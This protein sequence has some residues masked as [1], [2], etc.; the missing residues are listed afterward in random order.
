MKMLLILITVFTHGCL[1]VPGMTPPKDVIKT[2]SLNGSK[3][4]WFSMSSAYAQVADYVTISDGKNVDTICRATNIADIKV[5]QNHN[6]VIGFYGKPEMYNSPALLKKSE[7]KF[8]I[9]STYIHQYQ[10]NSN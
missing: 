6:L 9:D 1:L 7:F 3:I 5:P 2:V 10:Q 4:E 8:D